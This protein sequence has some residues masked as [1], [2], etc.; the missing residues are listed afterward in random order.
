MYIDTVISYVQ[1]LK[2]L[3]YLTSMQIV[4]VQQ[5]QIRETP[6]NDTHHQ[7]DEQ[8]EAVKHHIISAAN[9]RGRYYQQSSV[10]YDS[11]DSESDTDCIYPWENVSHA[12]HDHFVS[13]IQWQTPILISG[14]PGSGKSHTILSTVEHLA[15][16]DFSILIASPTGYLSS[17]FR[18]NVSSTVNC[19]TIHAAFQ[20]PVTPSNNP[21][22]NWS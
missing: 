11:D 16:R 21:K 19:D 20:F 12:D 3:L 6:R 5:L 2:D 10:Q 8:Q 1:S 9:A 22:T 18:A 15:D 14:K 13:D 7:L 17:V 4:S